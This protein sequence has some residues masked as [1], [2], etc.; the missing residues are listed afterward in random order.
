MSAAGTSRRSGSRGRKSRKTSADLVP[1]RAAAYIRP[2]RKI[3]LTILIAA[4]LGGCGNI[5]IGPV[6][7]SCL[8]N[9]QRGAAGS[10]CDRNF[11]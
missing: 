6:D 11:R 4:A 5:P 7:H 2:M 10:G 9:P 3:I 8:G 1:R